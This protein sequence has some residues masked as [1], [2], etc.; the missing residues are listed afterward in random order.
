MSQALEPSAWIGPFSLSH[1][2]IPVFSVCHIL[3]WNKRNGEAYVKSRSNS[4]GGSNLLITI[5]ELTLKID[6]N[7]CTLNNL[8]CWHL[9]AALKICQHSSKGIYLKTYEN[10][11]SKDQ[12]GYS[13][14]LRKVSISLRKHAYSNTLKIL[15]PKH[16]NFSDKKFWYF[17]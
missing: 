8:F 4:F 12:P 5:P 7:L 16:G 9:L 1:K 6:G 14:R 17:S 15:P 2:P 11:E 13:Q 10:C 3:L